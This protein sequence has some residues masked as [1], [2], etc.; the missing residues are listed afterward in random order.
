MATILN[1]A[2]PDPAFDPEAITVLAAAF[3]EAWDRL[4]QSGSEC[5][6]PAYARAMKEIYW[7]GASSR[8]R[9]AAL[10]TNKSLVAGATRFI[11]TNYRL[12]TISPDIP[13]R[14]GT[15]LQVDADSA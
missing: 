5:V 13:V 7:R 6:R 1:T 9:N 15:V 12:K 4:R 3:D 11:A 10:R 2:R 8:W 14:P